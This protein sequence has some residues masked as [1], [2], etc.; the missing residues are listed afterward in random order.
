MSLG[1]GDE[2]VKEDLSDGNRNVRSARH[3]QTERRTSQMK[4]M[5]TL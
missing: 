1:I 2:E 3:A 4:K 5:T